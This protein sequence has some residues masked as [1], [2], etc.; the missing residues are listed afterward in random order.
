M[1]HHE[2]L[3]NSLPMI[4]SEN[5]LSPLAREMLSTDFHNRYA[6][7]HPGER[8]YQGCIYIDEIERKC[9]EM[10][11]QLFK[12]KYV[13]VRPISGTVSNL[14]VLFALIKPGENITAMDVPHGAHI[15]HAVFGAVG[16][17]GLNLKTYPFDVKDMNIKVDETI[18]LIKEFKPKVCLFGQSVYLFPTP[19]KEL[20]DAFAEVN[21]TVVY[22]AAHVLG[23]IAGGK[24]QQPFEEGA[25]VITGSTHKTFFGP[26]RG[27]IL[28]NPTTE[29]MERKLNF[30]VFPG[31]LSNHHLHT[32]ASFGI[33][34]AEFIE[35]G[36]SYAE[37]VVK[38][39]KALASALSENG[40]TVLCEHLGFTESHT[41]VIDVRNLGGATKIVEDL[42][43]CNVI[44][45]K[46]LLPWDDVN[47]ALNPSG[48]RLGTQELTR[49]GMKES[50]MK[51]IANIFR[52]LAIE[53]KELSKVKEQVVNLRKNFQE[54]QY[55]FQKGNPYEYYKFI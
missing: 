33:S 50:E 5:I 37:Q 21:A 10:A 1:Q 6:E 13:D 48:I 32:L 9:K 49:L 45:N 11:K 25:N 42:E 51:E 39:A 44:T 41:L 30:A 7:G 8:Y 35:F 52:R 23:L 4:A 55:C 15:S 2:W 12:C 24:F 53:K 47:D 19:L 28:A 40:F 46:N 27:I 3:G 16:V 18:K 38:N 34:I 31:V 54:V 22:D 26:Q 43:K 20:R 29:K 17:R 36:K 14:A